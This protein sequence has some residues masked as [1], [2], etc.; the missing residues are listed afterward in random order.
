MKCFLGHKFMIKRLMRYIDTSY[1]Y[2]IPSTK[3]FKVCK[4]C[5]KLEMSLEK[6]LWYEKDL[7]QDE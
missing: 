5:G 4:R 7:K 6:G 2:K 3:V 1:G